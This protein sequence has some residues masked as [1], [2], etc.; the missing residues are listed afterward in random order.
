MVNTKWGATLGLPKDNALL[1]NTGFAAPDDVR[2]AIRKIDPDLS[3]TALDIVAQTG[4]DPD[5]FSTVI[6]VGSLSQAIGI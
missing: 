1:L 3:I 4:I 6:P 2:T 5:T